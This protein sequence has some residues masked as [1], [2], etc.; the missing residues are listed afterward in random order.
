MQQRQRTFFKAMNATSLNTPTNECAFTKAFPSVKYYQIIQD[1]D[2]NHVP[3][4]PFLSF[5]H[6]IV[7]VIQPHSRQRVTLDKSDIIQRLLKATR[8]NGVDHRYWGDW[9]HGRR[10]REGSECDLLVVVGFEPG[11]GD[12]ALRC[13]VGVALARA[14]DL[15]ERGSVSF[16]F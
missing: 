15:Y 12:G 9:A 1:L 5:R 16:F 7:Q 14:N 3:H 13:A 2:Q 4:S 10:E 8:Q 11:D 6:L